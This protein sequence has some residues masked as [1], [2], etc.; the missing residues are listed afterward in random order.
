MGVE[1]RGSMHKC[2]M[3]MAS[4]RPKGQ[5]RVQSKACPFAAPRPLAWACLLYLALPSTI[6]ATH[7]CAPT[8][9]A[10]PTPQPPTHVHA[11]NVM[12]HAY[13]NAGENMEPEHHRLD[14]THA[15]LLDHHPPR[16]TRL[17]LEVVISSSTPLMTMARS[18]R[19]SRSSPRGDE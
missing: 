19:V 2:Q 7:L 13:G 9:R 10:P 18:S 17:T 4:Q 16:D 15:R 3:P 12:H 14:M 11:D 5:K 8:P 1:R 6:A